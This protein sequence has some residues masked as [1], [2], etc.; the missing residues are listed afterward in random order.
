MV[1]KVKTEAKLRCIRSAGA[2]KKEA[3]QQQAEAQQQKKNLMDLSNK[4]RNA[5]SFVRKFYDGKFKFAKMSNPEKAEFVEEVLSTRDFKSR[6]SKCA[7]KIKT[8]I[9]G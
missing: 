5:P 6:N 8:P 4:L 7:T 3:E 9:H 1:A 2:S